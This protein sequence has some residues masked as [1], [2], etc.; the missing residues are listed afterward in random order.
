LRNFD[1]TKTE[2][3]A[4][5]GTM[6][7][8][9]GA[10]GML[11]GGF[12]AD[13]LGKRDFRWQAWLPGIAV[14]LAF[15]FALIGFWSESKLIAITCIGLGYFCYQ[16]SHATG[17]AVVQSVV[18]PNHRAQAAAFVFLFSS[19]IGLGLGP[20]AVGFISDLAADS[21]GQRSLSLAL[22]MAMVIL[23]GAALLYQ[24]TAKAMGAVDAK[25][26]ASE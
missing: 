4:L 11:F 25:I 19:M 24:L 17:L 5:V 8:L 20:L 23:L 16:M 10:P 7:L 2:T 13:R 9:A 18:A 6:V 12:L 15:P 14:L 3:G 1:I 26:E 22:T 21:F